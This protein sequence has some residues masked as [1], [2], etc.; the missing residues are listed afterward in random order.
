MRREVTA[1]IYGD[2]AGLHVLR[3]SQRGYRAAQRRHRPRLSRLFDP[4]G[5]FALTFI[6]IGNYEVTAQA[7]GFKEATF[8]GVT[9][10]VNDKRRIDFSLQ[11]GQVSKR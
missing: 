11:V 5:A 1:G 7:V 10:A 9:L 6:P 3:H 4:S 2:R 8:T